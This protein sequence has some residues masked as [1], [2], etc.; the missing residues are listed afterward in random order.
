MVRERV[1]EGKNDDRLKKVERGTFALRQPFIPLAVS[2]STTDLFTPSQLNLLKTL[3]LYRPAY[4]FVPPA[5]L[6]VSQ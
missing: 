1:R 4:R 5:I 3:V 6:F 2:L